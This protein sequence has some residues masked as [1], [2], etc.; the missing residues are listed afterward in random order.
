M[1]IMSS[2]HLAIG[3]PSSPGCCHNLRT[4]WAKWE[5]A[6]VPDKE[7]REV[8]ECHGRVEECHKS[9]AEAQVGSGEHR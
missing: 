2:H 7:H 6:G 4:T 8:H 1:I 9:Q 5:E 3:K